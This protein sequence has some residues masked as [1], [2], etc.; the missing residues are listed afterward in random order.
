VALPVRGK[1]AVQELL[2]LGLVLG[3]AALD[4]GDGP[5]ERTSGVTPA[6]SK[7]RGW[8]GGSG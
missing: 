6:I 2:G 8:G 1:S 5:G 4:Q 3:P 7:R